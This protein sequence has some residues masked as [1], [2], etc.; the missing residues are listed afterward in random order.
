MYHDLLSAFGKKGLCVN[1]A[2][3]WTCSTGLLRFD[4]GTEQFRGHACSSKISGGSCLEF[5]AP[6]SHGNSWLFV[7]A[8]THVQ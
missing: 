8:W 6:E 4:V 3:Y 2:I 5:E 1:G 7:F